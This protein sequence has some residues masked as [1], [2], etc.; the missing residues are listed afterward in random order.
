[1]LGNPL[2]A[3][4]AEILWTSAGSHGEQRVNGSGQQA[5]SGKYQ[6]GR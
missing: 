2:L 6:Y 5:C 3:D 4:H 1:M